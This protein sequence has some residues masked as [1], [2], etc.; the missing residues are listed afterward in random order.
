MS[1]CIKPVTAYRVGGVFSRASDGSVQSTEGKIVFARP[2]GHSGASFSL[3]CG[4]CDQCLGRRSAD[5]GT[6][7]MHEARLHADCHFVTFTYTDEALAKF[8]WSLVEKHMQDMWKRL[9]KAV[10]P[11]K[12]R[13]CYCGEYGDRFGRPHFHAIIFGLALS[14]LEI[15]G[16]NDRGEFLY[17]SAFLTGVWG[18]GM[19]VIGEVTRES[20]QYVASYALKNGYEDSKNRGWPIVD[21]VTGEVTCRRSPFVR[22]SSHPGIGA[23]F[24]ERFASDIFPVDAIVQPGGAKLPVP[25]YYRKLL[26]REDPVS[27]DRLR[28]KRLDALSVPAVRKDLKPERRVV[29]AVVARA[30]RDKG[31]RGSSGGQQ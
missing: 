12:L 16:K 4:H 9:R 26:Q 20:C 30:A 15:H 29:R 3:P 10:A 28:L 1:V 14:D 25:P 7:L 5:W 31:T 27:S 2:P 22:F 24:Y 21:A 13:Y 19:V 11:A 18:H 17:T 23:G 6:R 8:G